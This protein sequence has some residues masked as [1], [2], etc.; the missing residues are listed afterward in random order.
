MK[1]FAI[2]ILI[3]I[4]MCLAIVLSILI[5]KRLPLPNFTSHNNTRHFVASNGLSGRY[6]IYP[7]IAR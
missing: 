3:G 4:S 2:A 6:H 1:K 7:A 5:E